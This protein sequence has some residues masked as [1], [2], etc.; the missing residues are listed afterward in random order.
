[1]FAND[2]STAKQDRST[3]AVYV[4]GGR[5]QTTV[6]LA[7]KALDEETSREYG[8]P[9]PAH[10]K[11]V[12]YEGWLSYEEVEERLGDLLLEWDVMSVNFHDLDRLPDEF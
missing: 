11:S 2:K 9:F 5:Y 3:G 4:H 10:V 1:M 6:Q 7:S 8:S 12:S